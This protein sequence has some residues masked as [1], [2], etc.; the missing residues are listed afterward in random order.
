LPWL[1]GEYAFFFASFSLCGLA[2]LRE[3]KDF[4]VGIK[5]KKVPEETFGTLVFLDDARNFA[6]CF[7]HI[8][9]K[10]DVLDAVGCGDIGP[11]PACS[12]RDGR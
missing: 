4:F 9:G 5:R 3:I 11:Q 6:R 10:I 2:V 7:K 12:R 8:Q 1:C